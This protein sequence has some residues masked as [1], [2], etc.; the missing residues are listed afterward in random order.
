MSNL[1]KK[2]K[3][4]EEGYYLGIFMSL[5]LSLGVVFGLTVL[6]IGL[7]GLPIGVG[8]CIGLAIGSGMDA[9]AKKRG[10]TI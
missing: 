2:H 8:M 7:L 3:L 4:V 6:D 9:D 10:K 1:Q 5:G